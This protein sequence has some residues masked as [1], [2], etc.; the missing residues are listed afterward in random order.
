MLFRCGARPE[1][2]GITAPAGLRIGLA[3][4]EAVGARFQLADHQEFRTWFQARSLRT[5]SR[6]G[7]DV[8]AVANRVWT[9]K[10]Y[11]W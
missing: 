3:R 7:R 5:V 11:Q 9:L 1:G 6:C 4:I 10:G 8:L 2:S